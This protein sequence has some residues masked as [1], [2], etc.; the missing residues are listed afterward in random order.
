MNACV[1][2]RFEMRLVLKELPLISLSNNYV[3]KH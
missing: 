1:I 3:Y 2:W